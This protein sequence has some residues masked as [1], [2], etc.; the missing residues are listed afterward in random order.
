[1]ASGRPSP[2]CRRHSRVS[3]SGGRRPTC[4]GV[5][6]LVGAGV[7][8]G[9]DQRDRRDGGDHGDPEQRAQP[10]VERLVQDQPHQRADH[11][12]GGVGG[13]VQTEHPATLPLRHALDEQGVAR[14]TAHALAEP[15]GDTGQKHQRPDG[16]QRDQQLAHRGQPVSR[17]DQGPPVEPVREAPGGHLGD[18]RSALG[19]ALDRPDRGGRGAQHHGQEDRQDRIEEFAGRVLQEGDPGQH[20]D[21][22]GQPRGAGSG[23]SRGAAGIGHG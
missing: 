5:G 14:R 15:V 20:L 11:R 19:R 1:M 4:G 9:G 12:A 18:R 17:S 3:R 22:A 21:V 13:P 23:R 7:A 6:L 10:M 8:D 2:L 16:R